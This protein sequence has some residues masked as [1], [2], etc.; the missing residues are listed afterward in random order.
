GVYV[1]GNSMFIM[2]GGKIDGNTNSGNS[3]CVYV[4][5]NS[6]FIMTDGEITGNNISSTSIGSKLGGGVYVNNSIFTMNGGKISGN[7]AAYTGSSP[8][9]TNRGYG[10]GVYVSSGTLTVGGTA[11]ISGNTAQ[12]ETNNVQLRD[13]A[14]IT[15]G[16]SIAAMKIG[17]STETASGVIV[18]S[19]AT[20]NDAQYFTADAGGDYK[21]G[22]G[23]GGQ[24]VISNNTLSVTYHGNDN[25]GGTAPIDNAPYISGA[26]AEVLGAG[27][28][29]KTGYY[30][31]FWNTQEDGLGDDYSEGDEIQIDD[32]TELYAQWEP[33]TKIAKPTLAQNEFT[34]NDEEKNAE[35][36]ATNAAYTLSENTATNVGSYKAI[37]TLTDTVHTEWKDGTTTDLELDW[38]IAKADP[39]YTIP[40]DLEATYGDQLSS[41]T[42]PSGWTWE[43]TGT[44]GNAGPQTHKATFTPTDIAN[45]N[46]ATGI[47]ITITVAKAN[48]SYTIPTDLEATYGDQLS[49]VTLPSGWAW[50]ETGTVGNAGPQTHKAT[51]TPTDIANYNTATGI[52][53]TIAVAKANPIVPEV[54]ANLTAEEGQKLAE[55][56]LPENWHWMDDTEYV[57]THGTQTHKATFVPEDTENYNTIENIDVKITVSSEVTP[58]LHHVP[59]PMSHVPKYYT[60]KGISLGTTKPTAPGIY[61]EAIGVK[62]KRI[63]V[64]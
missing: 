45:Y 50:E 11:E 37:V 62:A 18:E 58:I 49:S 47:N 4:S 14:Y 60:L 48:P 35:L 6:M 40:T 17:I 59:Y 63:V 5:N 33:K 64:R 31:T 46:T 3:G 16:S 19:G 8:S 27:S 34:Y 28:L 30:F 10:G 39:S 9:Y 41:V 43:S 21:V 29:S 61:I 13:G 20:S 56:V 15:L 52:N 53:I 1:I 26:R 25:T 32:N 7:S 12:G 24:L 36:D 38:S 57:G 23:A 54:P 55:I 42:L 2:N 44:V 22:F 51:F